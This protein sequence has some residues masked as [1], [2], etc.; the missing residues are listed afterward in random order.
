MSIPFWLLVAAAVVLA[1]LGAAVAVAR[2][3]GRVIRR[4]DLQV[5]RDE[6]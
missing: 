4:R 6:R 1:W 5:P 3:I 2:L